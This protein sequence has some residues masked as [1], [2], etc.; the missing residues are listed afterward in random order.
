MSGRAAIHSVLQSLVPPHTGISLAPSPTAGSENKQREAGF[1]KR[2]REF[3]VGRQCAA[4]AVHQVGWRGSGEDSDLKLE[5][6]TLT[7]N[8]LVAIVGVGQDRCPIWP[9]G[10]VGS[11]SHSQN[12][13][14]AVAASSKHLRGIGI[15]TEVCLAP[16]AHEIVRPEVGTE[17]E[18]RLLD[19]CV[20][21]PAWATTLLFS[22]KEAY[23]KLWYPVTRQF[24]NFEDVQLV[25]IRPGRDLNPSLA[26]DKLCLMDLHSKRSWADPNAREDQVTLTA[27]R[28]LLVD[29][30][31]FSFAWIPPQRLG[32]HECGVQA[33]T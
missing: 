14:L 25:Q 15:D 13:T 23:F 21:E 4:E 12:W 19:E 30:D 17:L 5:T 10:Y 18:W 9:A 16:D 32:N 8:D 29:Q 24:L 28:V 33:E 31:I 2:Q 3:F 22:A 26:V 27:V 20:A 11:I 1:K 6:E 7:L